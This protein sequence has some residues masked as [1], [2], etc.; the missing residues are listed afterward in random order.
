MNEEGNI[1]RGGIPAEACQRIA[2]KVEADDLR[3][4]KVESVGPTAS[5]GRHCHHE[6]SRLLGRRLEQHPHRLA[7]DERKVTGKHQHGCGA[8]FDSE[9]D[10]AP[11]GGVLSL[12]ARLDDEVSS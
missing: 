1:S 10:P 9:R 11:G 4:T 6:R 7:V 5:D 8:L 2:T 12:L 3:W